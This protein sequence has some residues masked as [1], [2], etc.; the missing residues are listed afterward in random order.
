MSFVL[1]L[2]PVVK[3]M[4]PVIETFPVYS[5]A[6]TISGILCLNATSQF[7]NLFYKTSI[8]PIIGFDCAR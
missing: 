1:Q 5:M 2:G 3:Q 6:Q 7:L 4:M 8:A